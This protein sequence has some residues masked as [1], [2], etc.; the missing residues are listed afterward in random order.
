MASIE[1]LKSLISS[2]HGLAMSN[3]F[4]IQIP[5]ARTFSVPGLSNLPFGIGGRIQN[6]FDDVVDDIQDTVTDAIGN[7]IPGGVF[8]TSS[9]GR[10]LDL[11]CKNA[12]IPGKQI[13]TMDRNTGAFPEK[14]A[15]GYLVDDISLTFHILN[16]YGVVRFFDAWRKSI[17]NEDTGE[18][19][20][21]SDYAR[22]VKIH[23]LRKPIPNSDQGLIS[24]IILGDETMVYSIT[25][26]D[27]FPTT[28]QPIEFVNELDGISEFGVQLSYTNFKVVE[29]SLLNGVANMFL[30]RLGF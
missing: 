26:E 11:L 19:G 20:Y 29:T 15:Y 7:I 13:A 3:Q 12:S 4:L 30:N 9:S 23:Q 25:L 28:V 8:G 21:K 5:G 1:D 14:I 17:I 6:A 18:I 10:D 2:K 22:D 16:D 27:A 24:E